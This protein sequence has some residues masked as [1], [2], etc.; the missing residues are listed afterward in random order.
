MQ[1]NTRTDRAYLESRNNLYANERLPEV[2][3]SEGAEPLWT[4]HLDR[5]SRLVQV[6][7]GAMVATV[8][9]VIRGNRE[10]DQSGSGRLGIEGFTTA[11]YEVVRMWYL[12]GIVHL[13]EN[14]H[15][16]G[17]LRA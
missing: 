10:L 17:V 3:H 13:C 8:N 1:G 16:G 5:K 4:M 9:Q 12:L 14:F 15:H 6:K 11:D 7:D 2:P